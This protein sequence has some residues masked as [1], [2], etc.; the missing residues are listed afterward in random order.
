MTSPVRE[1]AHALRLTFQAIATPI[2][3][4]LPR[5]RPRE[6]RPPRVA[7][8]SPIFDSMEQGETWAM[9]APD[10]WFMKRWERSTRRMC[11]AQGGSA[12]FQFAL[13]V[14]FQS[15]P[16]AASIN[17]GIAMVI[18]TGQDVSVRRFVAAR[19]GLLQALAEHPNTDVRWYDESKLLKGRD[20]E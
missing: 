6:R 17:Y 14:I 5:R 2:R 16:L 1:L 18:M 13:P 11:W 7:I 10:I 8:Q 4:V 3:R 15:G 20:A 9:V 12:A 19:A